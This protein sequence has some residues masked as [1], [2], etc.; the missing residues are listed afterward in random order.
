MTRSLYVLVVLSM[1]YIVLE[2]KKE[3]WQEFI[4][5]NKDHKIQGK[6]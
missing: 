4:D 2:G 6:S 3:E 1:A 5:R